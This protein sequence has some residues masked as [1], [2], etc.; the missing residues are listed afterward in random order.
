MA[1]KRLG[2]MLIEAGAIT[3]DNLRVALA[4]QTRWGRS[5]GQ[6]LVELRLVSEDVLV[7]VLAQQ[8]GVPTVELDVLDVPLAV[9]E[10]VPA[11]FAQQHDV[12]PFALQM[13]FLDVAM[14]DPAQAATIDEL[15]MRTR[16]NIRPHLAGPKSMERA[17]AKYYARGFARQQRRDLSLTV[18][19]GGD[20]ELELADDPMPI[21]PLSGREE[22]LIALQDRVATLEARFSMLVNVLAAKGVVAAN[23][24]A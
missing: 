18:E 19:R 14:G 10:L 9:I 16:L 12:V 22:E 7:R 6:T 3:E 21:T 5:L 1:R 2:T 13:K 11:D 20:L 8:L 4:E 23:E 17:L 15:R 24:V